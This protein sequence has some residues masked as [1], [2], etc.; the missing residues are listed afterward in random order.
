MKIHWRN[1]HHAVVEDVPTA[2]QVV[3]STNVIQIFGLNKQ[4]IFNNLFNQIYLNELKITNVNT[5]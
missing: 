3:S 5:A 4:N 1:I 2:F